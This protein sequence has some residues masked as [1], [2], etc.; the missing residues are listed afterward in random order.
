MYH[1][2]KK[3]KMARTKID[4]GIDL[5]TTNSAI[6]RMENGESALIKITG[7]GD[8]MPSCV[9]Y[10][11]NGILIGKSAYGAYRSEKEK[12]L[13]K[14]IKPNAFIEFKRTMGTDKKY[15]SEFGGDLSSEQLSAEVL[16]SLKSFV[17]DENFSSIVITIPTAFKANQIDT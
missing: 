6:S 14:K 4:Y 10:N 15:I 8:T 3:N 11:R 5:G 17:T 7:Q 1:N 12:S 13:S 16:K 9:A 2:I